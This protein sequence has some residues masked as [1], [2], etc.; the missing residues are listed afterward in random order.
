MTAFIYIFNNSFFHSVIH[1]CFIH[2]CIQPIIHSF[3][4]LSIPLFIHVIDSVMHSCT[5]YSLYSS[6]RKITFNPN[7]I[8]HLLTFAIHLALLFLCPLF[9]H[10]QRRSNEN[11]HLRSGPLWQGG[12]CPKHHL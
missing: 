3:I 1:S 7:L 11:D 6:P 10:G 2:S 8:Y 12:E 4:H 5:V 9:E